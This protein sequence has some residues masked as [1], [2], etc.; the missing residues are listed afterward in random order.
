MRHAI[1]LQVHKSRM[2]VAVRVLHFCTF[3]VSGIDNIKLQELFGLIN[4]DNK[5]PLS[6]VNFAR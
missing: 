6:D 5:L 3:I 1:D 2:H 4:L